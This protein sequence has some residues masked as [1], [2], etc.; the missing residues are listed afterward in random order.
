[1]QRITRSTRH[2]RRF[3]GMALSVGIAA[4][5]DTH[6]VRCILKVRA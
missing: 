5:S 3:T 1:M 6:L 2:D 4:C